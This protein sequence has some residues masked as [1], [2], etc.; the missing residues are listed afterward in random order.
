[1][2]DPEREMGSTMNEQG[3]ALP[4]VKPFFEPRRLAHVSLWVRNVEKCAR[5][6]RDVAGIGEAY[7]RDTI[8]AIFLS[9]G[10]TYH[11]FSLMDVDSRIGKGREPGIHHLAFELENEVALVDGYNAAQAAGYKF[12]YTLSA[13]VAH[14]VYSSDPDGNSIEMYADVY[15]DWRTRR[16]GEMSGVKPEWKPGMTPPVAERCYPVN[17]PLDRHEDAIFHARRTAH[18]ALVVKDYAGA[19]KAYT[20]LAGLT[21]LVGGLDHDFTVLGGSLKELSL[22]LFRANPARPHGLHHIG[23]EVWDEA[24][25]D[26]G[27]RRLARAGIPIELEVDHPARRCV[28]VRDTDGRLVQFFVDRAMS[29]SVVE[30]MEAGMALYL[31]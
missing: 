29:P 10:N 1:L 27:E 25:I 3:A 22:S 31:C 14:S 19:L 4:Q 9:N 20:E 28:Y 2:K 15:A 12:D 23:I 6:Y 8:L 26:E 21:P 13:D 18:V 11:D 16:H 7:R 30:G 24:D 5:F 17:P